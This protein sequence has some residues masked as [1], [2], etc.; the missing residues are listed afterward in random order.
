MWSYVWLLASGLSEGGSEK[1]FVKN[2][3]S[4]VV[5]DDAPNE[6]FLSTST[7]NGEGK[8]GKGGIPTG[9]DPTASG[10]KAAEGTSS[11]G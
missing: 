8:E 1:I 3:S 7:G 6:V 10:V 11:G 2:S 9:K 5:Q 4:W